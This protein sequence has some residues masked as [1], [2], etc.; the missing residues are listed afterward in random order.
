MARLE[1]VVAL[2]MLLLG[3]EYLRTH[4]LGCIFFLWLCMLACDLKVRV[5]NWHWY[6]S[7]PVWVAM[8]SCKREGIIR[9]FKR[10]L[11]QIGY[12]HGQ[13][14]RQFEL[15]V[16]EAALVPLGGVMVPHV[17]AECGTG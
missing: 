12:T 13:G 1:D 8:C 10:H 17:A 14:A 7:M 16:A 11:P 9:F 2:V 6:R 15:L 3:C 4:S 5:Q